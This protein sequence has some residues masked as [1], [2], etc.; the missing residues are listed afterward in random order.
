[1]LATSATSNRN[2][3]GGELE[4]IGVIRVVATCMEKV[5]VPSLKRFSGNGRWS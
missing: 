1:M 4:L 3:K 2:T 5:A